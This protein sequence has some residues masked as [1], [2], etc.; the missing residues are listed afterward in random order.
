MP[1]DEG[2]PLLFVQDDR[3]DALAAVVHASILA[4]SANPKNTMIESDQ[5]DSIMYTHVVSGFSR[6]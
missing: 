6:T 5:S 2:L 4:T 1:A 3:D